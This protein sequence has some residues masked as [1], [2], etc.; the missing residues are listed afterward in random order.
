[1]KDWQKDFETMGAK[2][3]ELGKLIDDKLEGLETVIND[4]IQVYVTRL[5][6]RLC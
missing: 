4:K 3:N 2:L 5:C 1:M 6:P